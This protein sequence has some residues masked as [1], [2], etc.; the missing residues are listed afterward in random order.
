MKM[1]Q[2]SAWGEQLGLGDLHSMG[3]IGEEVPKG[4]TVVH[5]TILEMI[6]IVSSLQVMGL[7]IL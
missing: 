7:E 6:W 5:L 3:Q 2:L 1:D 4:Q